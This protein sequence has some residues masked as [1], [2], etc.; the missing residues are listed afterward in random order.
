MSKNSTKENLD[1]DKRTVYKFIHRDKF[2]LQNLVFR[3]LFSFNFS[4]NFLKSNW[5]SI[6]IRNPLGPRICYCA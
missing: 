4:F 3:F 2:K 5:F 6:D 1:K